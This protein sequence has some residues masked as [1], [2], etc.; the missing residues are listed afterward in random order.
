MSWQPFGP[1]DAITEGEFTLA[2]FGKRTIGVTRLRGTLHAVLN[3]CPHAGAPICSGQI[4]GYVT[5]NAP[6]QLGYDAE[7]K[8]LRCPWHHWEFDLE[9]GEGSCSG[10]GRIKTYPVKEENGE[11]WVDL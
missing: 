5:S 9:S 4:H 6:G 2:I 7:R 11:V 8:I 1:L 10:T 3:Y